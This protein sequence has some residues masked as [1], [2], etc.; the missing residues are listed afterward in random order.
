MP[1]AGAR[2]S[3]TGPD[4]S[5][6]LSHGDD[7]SGAA[8]SGGARL[9]HAAADCGQ[10]RHHS[11]AAN[12]VQY[13]A[14]Q[15]GPHSGFL[16]EVLPGEFRRSPFGSDRDQRCGSADQYAARKQFRR[17]HVDHFDLAAAN[18]L[19]KLFHIVS[20]GYRL[21]VQPRKTYNIRN[22]TTVIGSP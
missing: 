21:A 9:I 5:D 20:R 7:G 10:G 3:I 8:I 16:Q 13:L 22:C 1:G 12:F 4:V 14:Y 17:G 2:H 6:T 15:V 11:I 19:E 18:L